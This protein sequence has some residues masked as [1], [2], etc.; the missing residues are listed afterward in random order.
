MDRVLEPTSDNLAV[1]DRDA[2]LRFASPSTVSLLGYDPAA[3]VGMHALEFV[4]PDD[5]EFASA[6]LARLSG[7]R[8]QVTDLRVRCASGA[9]RSV[10]VAAR[11]YL[12]N[13]R[14]DR[15]VLVLRE[16]GDARAE[17][18]AG[19][20]LAKGDGYLELDRTGG[21][22]VVSRRYLELF[23]LDDAAIA[24]VQSSE[25]P[26]ARRTA[27]MA[28]AAAKAVDPAAFVES[29][30]RHLELS[31]E[32]SFEDISLLDG[33]T[34]ERYAAPVRDAA[35][36]ITG[37][38]LFMRD[39]T[40]RR[41]RDAELR[42]RARQQ[43]TVAELGELALNAETSQPLLTLAARLVA[44]TLEVDLVQVLELEPERQRFSLR[45]AN[46]DDPF[47]AE[48]VPVGP[49]SL[50]G[51]TIVQQAPQ[52]VVDLRSETRFEAPHLLALGIVSCISVVLRGR[53][54][55]F[56]V[57]L[58]FT[59][60]RRAFSDGEVHFLETVANVVSAMLARHAASC[61]PS[62][63]TRSTR[64]PSMATTVAWST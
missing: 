12:V 63:R 34:L 5:V 16:L 35:G 55:P 36:N 49:R 46:A 31:G 10:E 20:E 27:V 23:G 24:R 22:A 56:G 44:S 38:A 51:F 52:V 47:P 29:L 61:G 53:D 40:A 64:S 41:R 17:T 58:A 1:F 39:V 43:A 25:T 18:H 60:R 30:S 21:V 42:E 37:R 32:V 62:S 28:A 7:G 15:F 48:G 14:L 6:A 11:P 9:V 59:R 19:H 50:S 45:A 13:G 33:R 4:H 57:L 54:R 26:L 8:S 2:R 3:M